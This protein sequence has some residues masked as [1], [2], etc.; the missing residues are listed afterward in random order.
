VPPF[1]SGLS[2]SNPIRDFAQKAFEL[3]QEGTE[4]LGK[5]N[6]VLTEDGT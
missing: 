2:A 5:E 6:T 1:S 3:Q 4:T